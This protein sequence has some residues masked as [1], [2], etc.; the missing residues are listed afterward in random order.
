[1]TNFLPAGIIND[2]ILEI[3]SKISDLQKGHGI[4]II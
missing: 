3:Q 1:M 2:T 4:S